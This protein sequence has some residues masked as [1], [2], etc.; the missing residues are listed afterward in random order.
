MYRF[1]WIF[2]PLPSSWTLLPSTAYMF[3]NMV[4]WLTLSPQLSTW[5]IDDP[6]GKSLISKSSKVLL[7]KFKLAHVSPI[8]FFINIF[9]V[10]DR[11]FLLPLG[12][13]V[14]SNRWDFL[15]I[16]RFARTIIQAHSYMV[17]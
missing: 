1:F 6:L 4:I 13:T 12:Y 14:P 7:D 15:K 3:R 2:D 5:F 11:V 16:K 9:V 10:K 8:C 17:K